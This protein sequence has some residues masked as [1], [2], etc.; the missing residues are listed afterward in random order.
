MSSTSRT[1]SNFC[2]QE[3]EA[4]RQ[5]QSWVSGVVFGMY[6]DTTHGSELMAISKTVDVASYLDRT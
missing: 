3:H 1:R 4:F 5:A 2:L 6:E